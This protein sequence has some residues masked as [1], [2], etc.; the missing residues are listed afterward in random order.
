MN[1]VS[2]EGLSLSFLDEIHKPERSVRDARACLAFTEGRES[3][4]AAQNSKVTALN[5]EAAATQLGVLATAEAGKLA[6]EL[7]TI[8]RE[9]R[10]MPSSI[11]RRLEGAKVEGVNVTVAALLGVIALLCMSVSITVLTEYA[12]QS[13]ASLFS[14]PYTAVLFATLPSFA[15]IAIK[16]Q[17]AKLVSPDARWLYSMAWFTLG[18]GSLGVWL[19]SSAIAL[20]PDLGV[21]LALASEAPNPKIVGILLLVSTVLT[22]LGIGYT[23]LS[24]IG[25]LLAPKQDCESVANPV[26]E[27]LAARKASLAR[28]IAKCRQLRIRAENY[29]VRVAATRELTRREA[30]HDLACAEELLRQAETTGLALA[31]AVFFGNP[32]DES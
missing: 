17:E 6:Q 3:Y 5:N 24:G 12:L 27:T 28:D 2:F 4:L 15:A 8:E 21:S 9:L 26:F 20:A 25:G 11:S 14:R 29:L 7:A 13:S 10:W 22:E 18:M 31:S 32:E 16:V 1:G 19:V 30:L 23:I